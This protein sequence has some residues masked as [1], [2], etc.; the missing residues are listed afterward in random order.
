VLRLVPGDYLLAR[1]DRIREGGTIECVVDLSPAPVP[2]AE[3]HYRQH[4]QVFFRVACEP[5]RAALVPR[6]PTVTA[7]HTYLSKLHTGEVVRWIA[8][9]G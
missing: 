7:N 8:L 1:H 2:G 6:G 5:G 4:G 9:F 3:V